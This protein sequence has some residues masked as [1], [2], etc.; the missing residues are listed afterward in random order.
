[1]KIFTVRDFTRPLALIVPH[2]SPNVAINAVGLRLDSELD[3][4]SASSE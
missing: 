3:F 4:G 2:K 1:M